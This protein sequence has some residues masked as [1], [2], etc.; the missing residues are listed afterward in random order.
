VKVDAAA[1]L[2]RI[3]VQT[4]GQSGVRLEF[5]ELV[6][7]LDPYLSNSVQELD[8]PDLERLI[9]IPF[10]PECASDADWVLITHEHIDHCDPHTIPA[11]GAASPQA[12]F[13]APQPV[14]KILRGWGIADERILR[15][16]E[17][18]REIGPGLQVRATPAAHPDIC[19]DTDGYLSYVGYLLNY[20]GKL[21]YLAGD[22]FV[23]QEILD[24]LTAEGPIHTAFLPVNE[25]NF[26][27]GRRGIIGNMSVREAFQ[28][29]EEI[30][31]KQVVPVHWDMFAA[32]S[33]DPEEIRFI[34]QR[35]K[36]NFDL[37]IRPTKLNLSDVRISIIIRTL[38]EGRHLD[39]LLNAIAIQ[40]T[41]GLEQEVI[42]VD[43][44]STDAT[45]KIAQQHGCRI[46][47]ISRE[48]FSFGRSLNIGCEAANG[49]ILVI[50]SGHCVPAS[51]DWLFN[52]CQPLL[53]DEVSYT[54]G[55]QLGGEQSHYS[56]KRIFDKYFPDHVSNGQSEFFCNNA[57]AALRFRD[58]KQ[59]RFDEDLTGLEDMDL[60]QR[61]VQQAGKVVY[62]PDA[63]VYHYHEESWPQVQRRF[64]R[65]AIAL[66]RIMPQ[67]HVGPFDLVRYVISSIV[68]D[69]RCAL[70]DGIFMRNALDIVRYRW[71]QYLGVYKGNN[72]HRRLSHTD[73]EKYFYPS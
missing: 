34:H 38:N 20:Y 39:D 68:K 2:M 65:E 54:Y 49:D 28:F 22:T 40:N 30:G 42:I 15:A 29:A 61:L 6:V 21:I 5:G 66:Q 55:K 33:V 60:A 45:L 17:H 56:E 37:L 71:H 52:L 32:N 4:L 73:K 44:G 19:R 58:W 14:A 69:W 46:L 24:T 51:K 36:P 10:T 18:W 47:H 1:Y 27:R 23:R 16:D 8:A 59:F 70:S 48:D 7:F 31:C 67:V 3:P 26:F 43:S 11:L 9:P 72:D 41:N 57:N 50:T 53:E 25:H 64:E 35:L 12:C 63:T 13:L 62:V